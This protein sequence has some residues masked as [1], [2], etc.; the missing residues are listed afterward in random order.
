[1]MMMQPAVHRAVPLRVA[2]AV[3][4]LVDVIASTEEL[5]VTVPPLGLLVVVE[6]GHA[7]DGVPCVKVRAERPVAEAFCEIRLKA[8]SPVALRAAVAP[9]LAADVAEALTTRTPV[10]MGDT[11][12][13]PLI[14]QKWATPLPDVPVIATVPDTSAIGEVTT[15]NQISTS[16]PAVAFDTDFQRAQ[17]F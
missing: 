15:V 8:N 6:L 9:E 2:D 12:S 5:S 13:A 7:V 17:T 16:D 3:C 11:V 4:A 1:M 10:S 14:S